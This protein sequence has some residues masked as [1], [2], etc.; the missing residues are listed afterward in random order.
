MHYDFALAAYEEARFCTKRYQ[1]DLYWRLR[2]K[3]D[4]E[5]YELFNM[6]CEL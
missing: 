2:K 6:G 4:P 1:S 5:W 3:V